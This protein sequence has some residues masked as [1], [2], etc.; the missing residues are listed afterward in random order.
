MTAYTESRLVQQIGTAF[1]DN[2][3]S[4][5]SS[6]AARRVG[7][8]HVPSLAP[9]VAAPGIPAIIPGDST[10]S[11]G[12]HLLLKVTGGKACGHGCSAGWVA[13]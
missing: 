10:R 7:A 1:A 3:I 13:D 9:R 12:G 6:T 8:L 5:G 4:K 11:F 2:D